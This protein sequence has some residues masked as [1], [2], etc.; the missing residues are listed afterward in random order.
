MFVLKNI[1][2][3]SPKHLLIDSKLLHAPRTKLLIH[4][5]FL[6][7]VFA[8]STIEHCLTNTTD[9]ESRKA[10]TLKR[11]PLRQ[12]SFIGKSQHSVNIHYQMSHSSSAYGSQ[13]GE[14]T[15]SSVPWGSFEQ[16][17]SHD[18]ISKSFID[19]F[20]PIDSARIS[21]TSSTEL[22]KCPTFTK[23]YKKVLHQVMSAEYVRSREIAG[24]MSHLCKQVGA[25]LLEQ[26][27]KVFCDNSKYLQD[28]FTMFNISVRI[29]NN[30]TFEKTEFKSRKRFIKEK[31]SM[32]CG[33]VLTCFHRDPLTVVQAQTG[34]VRGSGLLS[35]PKS[36]SLNAN[37]IDAKIGRNVFPKVKGYIETHSN[38]NVTWGTVEELET[39]SFIEALQIFS[40]KSQ[41]SLTANSFHF[42]R[43][44]A[45]LLNIPD[46]DCDSLIVSG[47][48]VVT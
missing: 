12:C 33:I 28:F 40:D 39:Q 35:K 8:A 22:Q 16:F 3:T 13:S 1:S 37:T 43:V 34:N 21:Q 14:P 10:Y 46:K 45:T 7:N 36:F 24:I 30:F 32:H 48:S 9:L 25:F 15:S 26:I 4:L 47:K 27:L 18:T 29:A 31:V 11:C 6:Q 19:I 5:R 42:C 17:D 38:D 41:I 44:H 2:R 23:H 20:I